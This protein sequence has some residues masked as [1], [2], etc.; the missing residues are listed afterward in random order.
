MVEYIHDRR[1]VIEVEVIIHIF[2]AYKEI[3]DRGLLQ[4]KD[5]FFIHKNGGFNNYYERLNM[6]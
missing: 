6:V 1:E 4:Y 5:I 3:Q 2:L